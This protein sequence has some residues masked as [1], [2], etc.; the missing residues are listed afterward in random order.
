MRSFSVIP[1][2]AHQ[3]KTIRKRNIYPINVQS[4]NDTNSIMMNIWCQDSMMTSSNGNIFRVAGPLCGNSPV[5][6]EFPSQGQWR[7]AWM[8]SLICA[9]TN[10]WVNNRDAC[11]LRC[12]R[13]HYDISV[14]WIFSFTKILLK[15]SLAGSLSPW[16]WVEEMPISW[17]GWIHSPHYW[18][19]VRGKSEKG[20]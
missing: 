10:G 1:S 8:I 15:L 9:W 18:P 13:A 3:S 20:Q 17:L 11:D 5:T 12:H 7:G 16:A 19:F 6:G 14:M 4:N 2:R